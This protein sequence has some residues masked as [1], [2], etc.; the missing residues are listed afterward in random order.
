MVLTLFAT[1]AAASAA[2]AAF[3]A[4]ISGA[5]TPKHKSRYINSNYIKHATP[6]SDLE[7]GVE[8]L[9]SGLRTSAD[10]ARC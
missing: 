7:S 3:P 1:A 4:K 5:A 9:L 2:F 6:I 8:P 10:L